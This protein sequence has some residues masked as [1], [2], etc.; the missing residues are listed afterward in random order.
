V[1]GQGGAIL[2]RNKIR[3]LDNKVEVL[4]LQFEHADVKLQKNELGEV[5]ERRDANEVPPQVRR[6]L[7]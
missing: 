3:I 4:R 7:L 1:T 6:A 2:D 5:F